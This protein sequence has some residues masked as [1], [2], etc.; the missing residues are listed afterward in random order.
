MSDGIPLATTFRTFL[1]ELAVEVVAK[2]LQDFLCRHDGR[3]RE[4]TDAV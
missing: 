2:G 3:E 1:H 4:V